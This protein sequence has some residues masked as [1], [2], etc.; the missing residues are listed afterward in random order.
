LTSAL[1]P[2]PARRPAL[3]QAL[4]NGE[5]IMAEFAETRAFIHAD[6]RIGQLLATLKDR[7]L[8]GCCVAR[9]LAYNATLVAENSM[10]S[11]PWR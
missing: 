5:D 3:R 7:K 11:A 10:G 9:A 4:N 6:R 8:C 1:A 2:P